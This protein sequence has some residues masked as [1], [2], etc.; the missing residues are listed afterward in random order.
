MLNSFQSTRPLRGE[1]ACALRHPRP[2]FFNPLAPCGARRR[3]SGSTRSRL[4]F[5]STRPLRGETARVGAL[6]EAVAFFNP[7]A[8]CGA[9][10]HTDLLM[11]RIAVFQSTR[12]LRGET[13]I[14]RLHTIKIN[15]SIHS[16]LAGRD[17]EQKPPIQGRHIFNP[18]A[19]CGARPTTEKNS[20]NTTH[21]QSTRPLRGE[22]DELKK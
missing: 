8:P 7:L 11:R 17:V 3:S 15:F 9:R 21:F 16:P 5:Q 20:T 19:P 10:R 22:T 12:P 1:T 6:C 2:A 13:E 14:I 18:L 4:I